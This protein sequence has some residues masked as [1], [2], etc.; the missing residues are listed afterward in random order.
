[1]REKSSNS[2]QKNVFNSNY[3]QRATSASG[4][5]FGAFRAWPVWIYLSLND[6]RTKYR[7]AALGPLWLVFGIGIA[8]SGMA[9]AWSV[10]FGVSW[11]EYV[12]YMISGMLVW[13]LISGY[14]LQSCDMFTGEFSGL[15]KS[16]PAPPIIYALRFVMRGLWLFLH[17]L[18]FWVCVAVAT[19]TWPTVESIPYFVLGLFMT[20]VTALSVSVIVGMMAARFRDLSPAIGALMTPAMMV[21]PVM[22]KPEMLGEYGVYAKM[23]PLTHYVEVLRAPLLGHAPGGES[24][25]AVGVMAAFFSLLAFILYRRYRYTLVLW[26]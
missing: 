8:L 2:I 19:G 20:L 3:L 6:I 18:P 25:I 10:I 12:P 24:L 22:W 16:L 21:T 23:N 9:L 15:I 4:E 26:V 1:M 7:R 13:Q 14:I 17:Y 11:R 5:I